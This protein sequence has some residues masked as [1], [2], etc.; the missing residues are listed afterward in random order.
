MEAE[1][2]ELDPEER[3]DYLQSLGVSEGGL[4]SLV[5]ATYNLLGLR[6]YF[7]SGEK[8]GNLLAPC[9]V[10]HLYILTSGSRT[11]S[12]RLLLRFSMLGLFDDFFF[13]CFVWPLNI[14][15]TFMNM[16]R[17]SIL[18]SL[19]KRYCYCTN[20]THA[21]TLKSYLVTD[22]QTSFKIS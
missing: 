15:C 16:I 17:I 20:V 7:T 6:T 5:R 11:S 14:Y 12:F 1:L 13:F 18:L 2:T 19:L 8:V 22:Y 21:E 3:S 4:G 10:L 9:P